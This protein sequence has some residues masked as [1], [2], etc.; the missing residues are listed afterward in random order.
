M[1]FNNEEKSLK[2]STVAKKS[3]GNQALISKN[4]QSDGATDSGSSS[5]SDQTGSSTS[6]PINGN[7]IVFD[8]F[9]LRTNNC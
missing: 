9:E 3:T 6:V 8:S 1:T 7:A 5:D 4:L 2:R